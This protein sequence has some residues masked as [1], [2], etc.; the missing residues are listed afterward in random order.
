MKS[1]SYIVIAGF[2]LNFASCSLLK[3]REIDYSD[4]YVSGLGLDKSISS[5]EIKK[6]LRRESSMGGGNVQLSAFPYTKA[7]VDRM[8]DE[9]AAVRAMNPASKQELTEKLYKEYL[10]SKTCF[11]IDI[12]SKRTRKLASLAEWSLMARDGMQYQ[13]TLTWR[14]EDFVKP[15]ITGEFHD[16]TGTSPVFYLSGVACSGV[17]LDVRSGIQLTITASEMNFPFSRSET[18]TFTFDQHEF[19]GGKII[20]VEEA[21]EKEK[22]PNRP[23]QAW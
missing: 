5:D 17:P 9:T 18:L 2:A 6:N 19:K 8:A 12:S 14:Q 20:Q 4:K 21:A 10:D 23:Y 15:V 1:L 22:K 13:S 3:K 16:F 7:L 11:Q